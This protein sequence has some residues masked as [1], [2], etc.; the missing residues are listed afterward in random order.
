VAHTHPAFIFETLAAKG[1]SNP[2]GDSDREIRRKEGKGKIKKKKS[3]GRAETV[4]E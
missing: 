3:L 2:R 4:N 1:I